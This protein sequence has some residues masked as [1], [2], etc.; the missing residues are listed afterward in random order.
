MITQEELMEMLSYNAETG[1]FKWRITGRGRGKNAV[2]GHVRGDG[3]CELFLNGNRD[4]AHRMA[5]LYV[6][7]YI[8]S[9]IDHIDNNPSN[10]SI[11]N[12]RE[13]TRSANMGNSRAK[14][15]S[16]TGIKGVHPTRW[17]FS[18]QIT[19]DRKILHIGSY[20]TV[21][22]AKEAYDKKALEL[23]GEFSNG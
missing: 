16:K 17:G 7:G 6:H 18:A 9:E 21:E 19:K 8:P 5:W 22:D 12:L 15:K 10:N 1:E 2:A 23:F 13:A 4:Y 11:A 20:K 14:V 3:Y